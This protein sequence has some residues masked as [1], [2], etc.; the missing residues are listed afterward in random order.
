M[1]A[2][3]EEEDGGR[4]CQLFFL[5]LSHLVQKTK[6]RAEKGGRPDP[7]HRPTEDEGPDEGGFVPPKQEPHDRRQKQGFFSSPGRRLQNDS[8]PPKR[9]KASLLLMCYSF[10]QTLEEA[11]LQC[12]YLPINVPLLHGEA[13]KVNC[14]LPYMELICKN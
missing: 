2:L 8:S 3:K 1:F 4:D 5:L 14:P 12:K 11:L 10:D 6:E 7:T 13:K 9:K